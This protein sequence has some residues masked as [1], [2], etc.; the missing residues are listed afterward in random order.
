M[1]KLLIA[2]ALITGLS[3]TAFAVDN[4]VDVRDNQKTVSRF[5]KSATRNFG[6]YDGNEVNG[7]YYSSRRMCDPNSN[8]AAKLDACS[9]DGMAAGGSN[10]GSRNSRQ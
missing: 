9:A 6:A 4:N 1:K 2:T 10:N 5:D 8:G 7:T 3:A